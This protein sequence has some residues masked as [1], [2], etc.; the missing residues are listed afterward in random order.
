MVQ[1]RDLELKPLAGLLKGRCK[2]VI[3]KE[4]IIELDILSEKNFTLAF[5]FY[6]DFPIGTIHVVKS[7]ADREH[8]QEPSP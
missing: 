5:W 6:S 8:S 4:M 1:W 7:V 3:R 2:C